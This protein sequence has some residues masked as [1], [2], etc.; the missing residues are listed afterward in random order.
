KCPGCATA[1]TPWS[2]RVESWLAIAAGAHGLGYWPAQWPTAV[3]HAIAG[4]S[5]DVA[6]LGAAIYAPAAPAN[7]N[8]A[9]VQISARS[10]GGALYVFAINSSSSP[11]DP[12]I[13]V[14]SLNGRTLQVMNESRRLDSVGDS[15]TDH[16]A[17]LSVHLYIAAPAG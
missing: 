17:P 3:G 4:I 15:F 8:S 2:V 16:F 13:T 6:R 11:A 1:V 14:P 7:D 5:R 12:A 10:W 9:Q